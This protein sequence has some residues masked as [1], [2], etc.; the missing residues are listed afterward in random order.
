MQG[1]FCS[2]LDKKNGKRERTKEKMKLKRTL[3]LMI[4]AGLLTTSLAACVV[5]PDDPQN[6]GG[7]EPYYEAPTLPSGA[8]TNPIAPTTDP[9]TVVYAPVNQTVYTISNASLKPVANPND[10][11]AALP[12]GAITEMTRVGLHAVWSKVNYQGTEYYIAT[13]LL[14]TD[15][16]AQKTFNP[17]TKTL[18]VCTGSVNVRSYPSAENFSEKLG[19]RNLDDEIKVIAENGTWS[20]I[21]WVEN[22]NTKTGFIKS[23]F[24]STTKSN[25]NESDFLRYF[26]E[27]SAPKTMYVSTSAANL[28]KYP[29]ADGRGTLVVPDGLKLGTAVTVVAEGTVDGVDW[30]AV[31]WEVNS[32]KVTCYMAKKA[33]SETSGAATLEDIL[34]Q[35]PALKKFDA[36]KTLYVFEDNAFGRSAPTR[37]VINDKNNIV[38]LLYKGNTVTAVASGKIAG[39]D[40]N[41]NAEDIS[42]CLVK[43]TELGY[44]FVS[45]SVLT[46]DPELKPSVPVLTLDELVAS[47]GFE[48]LTSPSTMKAKEDVKPWSAPNEGAQMDVTIAKDTQV[49]VLAKGSTKEG[50]ATNEWYIIEYNGAHYFVIRGHFELA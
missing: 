41:G 46:S 48:K 21:E 10:A 13:A 31:E 23:E 26:S 34:E 22:G 9:A 20:K 24:L 50:F 1:A 33:L 38:K 30:Y 17:V 3:T 14:T 2:R 42:W 27:L 28:R 37:I 40:P 35:Y 18:Y 6:T 29:Y 47:Y 43:D 44:Y 25:V 4:L 11:S 36:D 8:D 12:L 5:K 45:L 19:S 7:S 16:L 15:D 49:T 39:Q 32:L